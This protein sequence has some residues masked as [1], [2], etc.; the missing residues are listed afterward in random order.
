MILRH[1]LGVSD[2]HEP[3]VSESD[4]PAER[5]GAITGLL[6]LIASGDADAADRLVGLVYPEL[7]RLAGAVGRGERP[8]HS[9][10]PTELVNEAYLRLFAGQPLA[11]KD[12]QHL[13]ATFAKIVRQVLVDHARSRGAVKRGGDRFQVTLDDDIQPGTEGRGLD[14]LALDEALERLS[15][16]SSRQARVVELRFFGGLSIPETASVLGIGKT[17]VSADWAVAR[18]WLQAE[19]S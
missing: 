9:L 17:Q 3:S 13:F 10:Q 8:G 11:L 7:R 2:E 15:E 18:A 16:L 1:D 19:L 4:A 5:P 6:R 12:R 14:L